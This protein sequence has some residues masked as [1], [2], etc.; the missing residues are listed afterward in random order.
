MGPWKREKMIVGLLL[1]R[2]CKTF[3][4]RQGLAA[5]C[6]VQF[7]QELP[8]DVLATLALSSAD[9]EWLAR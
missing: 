5:F 6:D 2:M 7:A 3:C 8:K 9:N 4:R 1:Y